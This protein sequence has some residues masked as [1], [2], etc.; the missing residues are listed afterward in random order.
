MAWVETGRGVGA[1]AA[2]FGLL[3]GAVVAA[4]RL[5]VAD[6]FSLLAAVGD[7]VDSTFFAGVGGLGTGVGCVIG[8]RMATGL[9][10][11]LAVTRYLWVGGEVGLVGVGSTRAVSSFSGAVFALTS[12][13]IGTGERTC[14]LGE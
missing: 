3:A 4:T 1:A 14:F 7:A 2:G 8:G 9:E 12:T 10:P 13:A 5:L 11:T 6:F